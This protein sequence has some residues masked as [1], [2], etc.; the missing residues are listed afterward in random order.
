MDEL[1]NELFQTGGDF[2]DK[3]ITCDNCPAYQNIGYVSEYRGRC[4]FSII[5][6]VL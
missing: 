1:K 2:C 3:Y 6:E 5:M 4:L